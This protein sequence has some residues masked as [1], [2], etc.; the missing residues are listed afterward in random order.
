MSFTLNT[1]KDGK[2]YISGGGLSVEY[3]PVHSSKTEVRIP[4]ELSKT[5]ETLH[6]QIKERYKYAPATLWG[7][8]ASLDQLY[9]RLREV[10][11]ARECEIHTLKVT[12]ELTDA[13][14]ECERIT[15]ER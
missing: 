2:L 13:Q 4:E 3:I 5:L 12:K 14:K 8:E 11:G 1:D 10:L 7:L 15:K 6:A 9:C